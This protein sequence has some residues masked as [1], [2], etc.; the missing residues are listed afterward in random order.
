VLA[1]AGGFPFAHKVQAELVAFEV[2]LVEHPHR[3]A[4][5]CAIPQFG[6]VESKV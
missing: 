2:L 4:Y 1:L 3:E 6:S 5:D